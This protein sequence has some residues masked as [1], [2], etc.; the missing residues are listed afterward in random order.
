MN[1]GIYGVLR[2]F[3]AAV[4]KTG[5]LFPSNAQMAKL[6]LAR[7][8]QSSWQK[9]GLEGFLNFRVNRTTSKFRQ[10]SNLSR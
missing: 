9:G 3:Y 4:P 10:L 8:R 5:S 2:K 6:A 1:F 7:Q